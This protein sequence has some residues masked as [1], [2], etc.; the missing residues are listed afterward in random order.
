M[1]DMV[2]ERRELERIVDGLTPEAFTRTRA[3]EAAIEAA[4]RRR[5]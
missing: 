3:A 2:S 5:V 1:H 4:K